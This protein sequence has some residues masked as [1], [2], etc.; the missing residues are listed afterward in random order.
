MKTAII[1]PARYASTRLPG[2]PL[3]RET[4][5]YLIQHVVEQASRS[6]LAD[7]VIVATDDPRIAAAV[8]SFDGDV[9][10]TR[11]DHLSGTDRV[12]EVA[13]RLDADVIVNLQGDEPLINPDALDYAAE[14]LLRNRL[15]E[16]STLAVPLTSTEQWRNPNC[17]KVVIGDGG[18]ALYFSR[19]PIPFVRDD[20]PNFSG[21]PFQFFQHLGLY[22]YRRSM[23]LQLAKTPPSPLE[24]LEKLEQLRVLAMGKRIQV[25]IVRELSI[26]VDT[27]QDYRRFVDAYRHVPPRRAAA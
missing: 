19:S 18:Q 4:G 17:V 22:A 14:L 11:R 15:A 7:R 9:V 10:M 24:Q 1:I 27:W 16:M 12:A 5:K 20:E 3:L 6:R 2:K 8:R 25:G 21:Q 13:A 23:L 26:G